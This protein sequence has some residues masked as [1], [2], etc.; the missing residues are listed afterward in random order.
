MP[1]GRLI[2]AGVDRAI[3]KAKELGARAILLNVSAPFHCPLM[4]PAADA[5][6]QALAKTPPKT[7]EEVMALDKQLA[8]Q[9][10]AIQTGTPEQLGALL[11]SD[12][13]RWRKVISD[14]KISAD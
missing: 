9:G 14:A 13:A 2:L 12:L 4:Q 7:F 3:E 6:A 8:A 5:M 10:M 11:R 1:L